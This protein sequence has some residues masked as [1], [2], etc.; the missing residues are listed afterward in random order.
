MKPQTRIHYAQ[1][2]EPVLLWLA[3]HPDADP[4]LY[5]LA[6]L[7]CLSPHHF[8]RVYRA[9]MG[10]NVAAT[11]Q[12]MRMHRAA[13]A[14]STG[15]ESLRD[16]AT[17]A[18]YESLAAFNRAFGSAFGMSPGRYRNAR[19]SPFN[20]Q[21]LGMY[22]VAFETFP[23]VI[24]A[25]LPH[26]GSYQEI[27]PVFDRL[28]MLAQSRGLAAPDVSGFGIY[29]DDPDQVPTAQLRSRAGVPVASD[30]LL[31]DGLERFEI[32]E[33]R[34]AVLSFTGPYNEMEAAY[35]WMFSEWL[36]TSGVELAD[37]PMFEEYL[38]DPHTT[39]AAQL[40][41]RIYMPLA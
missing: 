35:N 14:L 21:E 26:R 22:P 41:T 29:Y 12:R 39:P 31:S 40:K 33:G 28:F 30:A 38:N 25:T 24:L 19:S 34:C 11:V 18:G 2:L 17:R 16:V 6:D 37:F 27:G 20:P 36:P 8:H 7:A 9:M 10:E 4:E 1:R 15:N 23:G 13:V 5:R 3:T 32:P